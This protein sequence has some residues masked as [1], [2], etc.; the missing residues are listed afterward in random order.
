M[1]GQLLGGRPLYVGRAQKKK[2]RMMELHRRYEAE[3]AE[4]YTK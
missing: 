4:R 1:Q 2:E 3:R